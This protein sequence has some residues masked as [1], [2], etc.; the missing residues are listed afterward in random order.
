MYSRSTG[1]EQSRHLLLSRTRGCFPHHRGVIPGI[2]G[3]ICQLSVATVYTGKPFP[4]WPSFP[5]AP[6][7]LC[8]H[9]YF[10]PAQSR[11]SRIETPRSSIRRGRDMAK[12]DVWMS[13]SHS[14]RHRTLVNI[15]NTNIAPKGLSITS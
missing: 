12:E 2:P 4:V 14:T 1:N 8:L 13:G 10:S 3:M 7:R 6:G 5:G 15:T 11:G 9:F